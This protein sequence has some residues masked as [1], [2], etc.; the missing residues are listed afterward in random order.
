[1]AG[2]VPPHTWDE[3]LTWV[4]AAD[5][6]DPN[7]KPPAWI[8]PVQLSLTAETGGTGQAI[9][10]LEAGSYGAACG[11]GTWPEIRPTSGGTFT[12]GG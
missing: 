9:V 12:L 3:A 2:I 7:L 5:L 6:G 4:D 1:M 8:E 11:T 10:T